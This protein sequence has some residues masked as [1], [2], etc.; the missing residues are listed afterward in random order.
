[1]QEKVENQNDDESIRAGFG[2]SGVMRGTSSVARSAKLTFRTT[3]YLAHIGLLVF[4]ILPHSMK[5]M[6]CREYGHYLAWQ[7]SQRSLQTTM[8]GKHRGS[9]CATHVTLSFTT[10]HLLNFIHSDERCYVIF[11]SEQFLSVLSRHASVDWHI[12]KI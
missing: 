5:V 1:M 6:I 7:V 9:F 10:Y 4:V 12:L 8:T 3:N 11:T 2:K